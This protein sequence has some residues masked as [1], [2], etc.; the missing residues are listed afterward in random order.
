MRFRWMAGALG[1]L[2][3]TALLSAQAPAARPA[4][5]AAAPWDSAEAY[6]TAAQADRGAKLY[7]Q[8]CENCHPGG[9]KDHARMKFQGKAAYPSVYYLFKRMEDQPPRP[10]SITQQQ[11]ADIVAYLLKTSGFPSGPSELTPDYA[12]MKL[13]PLDEPGFVRLFNGRDLSGFTFVTGEII[14][15]A[16]GRVIPCTK[17]GG[18]VSDPA[19]NWVVRNG[20]LVC[21]CTEHGYFY[22]QKKYQNFT[23]RLD[24]R[25]ARPTAWEGP[26][27]LFG[28]NSGYYI[29]L[30]P[31]NAKAI[32]IEGKNRQILWPYAINSKAK[33]TEDVE[34]RNRM[35]NPLGEW[36]AIEIVAKDGQVRSYLNGTL[37]S[38]VTEHEFKA[39]GFLGFQNQGAE[40]HWRNIRVREE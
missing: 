12:A 32:A 34:A 39:P 28:G 3:T 36:N 22:T 4:A 20:I 40:L 33:F 8:L 5:K 24:Y 25:F 31:Q 17:P 10:K 1:L 23:L 37:I 6:Y 29:F 16:D 38:T 14:G 35:L 30:D 18:C 2:A 11:R 13:M 7:Q 19:P 26:D 27:Y 21:A 9:Y 15:G